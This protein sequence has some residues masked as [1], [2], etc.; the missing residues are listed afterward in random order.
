[1]SYLASLK[2]TALEIAT[3]TIYTP[4]LMGKRGEGKTSFIKQLA[5][6]QGL[7]L[8]IINLSA[9]EAADFCGLPYIKDNQT[10]YARPAFFDAGLIFLDEMDTVRDSSVKASLKSLLLDRAINGHKL[11]DDCIILAAGNGTDGNYDTVDFDD[12]LSD[13]LVKLPFIVPIDE[14]LAY[15]NTKYQGHNFL[16]FCEVKKEIFESLSTRTIEQAL[17]VSTK[18]A[19]NA[20][21]GNDIAR[22]FRQF[23]ELNIISWDELA[24]GQYKA[25]ELSVL[26]KSSLLID[27]VNNFYKTITADQS[28]QLNKFINGLD[29][30]LKA[31]YFSKLKRVCLDD[32][33]K[34][35]QQAITLNGLGFFD[36]QKNYLNE[37]LK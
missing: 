3:K 9:I 2:I 18:E 6:E 25:S 35:K 26:T 29:A 4:F 37:L 17:K 34:F 36:G 33:D 21:V 7:K 12:A 28:G 15:L 30:E 11:N 10:L 13:R 14:K 24:A 23:L 19:L 8:S 31:N 32:G 5:N 27:C 1:M 20:I 22:T 16:K